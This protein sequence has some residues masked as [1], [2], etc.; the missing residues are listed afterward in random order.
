MFEAAATLSLPTDPAPQF[1]RNPFENTAGRLSQLSTHPSP[2]FDYAHFRN[3]M[4][5]TATRLQPVLSD[6]QNES[7]RLEQFA[8]TVK[9]LSS[10]N[11]VDEIVFL[12]RA[13]AGWGKLL[14]DLDRQKRDGRNLDVVLLD[15]DRN[16]VHQI[17]RTLDRYSDVQSVHIVSHGSDGRV[18]L[19]NTEINGAAWQGYVA[20]LGG[21]RHSLTRSADISFYGCNLAATEEGRQ[22]VRN[23]QL[24]TGAD[25]AASND[26]TGSALAGG[27]WDL[28][29]QLGSVKSSR[30][31][32]ASAQWNWDH[33]LQ[34][35]ID[36]AWLDA[37]GPGP[38]YL[39]QRGETYVLQT[40][41]ATDGSA[42]AII[43]KDIVFDLNGH[44]VTYNNAAP[45]SIVNQSFESGQG[46]SA[47]GWD[48]SAAPTAERYQG[49]WIDN[50]VYDGDYS[51]R[52]GPS[53]LNQTVVSESLVTLEAETTYSLSA[54]FHK[55]DVPD[56]IA[57]V[58]LENMSDGTVYRV[59]YGNN[60]NRGIQFQEEV[61]KTG[62]ADNTYQLRVGVEGAFSENRVIVDDVKVQRT[63]TYGVAVSTFSWAA[64]EYVDFTSY[65]T[66]GNSLIR[67]GDIVQGQ[68]GGTWGHGVLV[69]QAA[70]VTLDNLNVTVAGANAS[71]VYWRSGSDGLIQGSH[72]T[73][74]VK[75]ILSRDNNHGAVIMNFEGTFA[76]NQIHNGP[77]VGLYLSGDA[78]SQVYGNTIRLKSKYTNAFAIFARGVGTDVYDNVIDCG[79]A[80]YSA[81]GIFIRGSEGARRVYD[82]TIR[83]QGMANN[84]EYSGNGGVQLGGAYGI[85]I[86]GDKN[87]EIFRNH[88]YV[89][90]EF[91]M[92]YAFRANGVVDNVNVYE[93]TFT[94][95]NRGSRTAVFKLDGPDSSGLQIYDNTLVT[96]DGIF[97]RTMNT[98]VDLIRS[99]LTIL[100]A[101]D[102]RPFEAGYVSA[103]QTEGH[104]T[105]NLVDTLFADQATRD[106]VAG[107]HFVKYTASAPPESRAEF[108]VR[109]STGFLVKDMMGNLIADAAVRVL[110]AENN[111]V[112]T[113]TTD[114]NGH[115]QI[116]LSE[117]HTTGDVNTIFGEYT[118]TVTGENSEASLSFLADRQQEIDIELGIN[119]PNHGDYSLFYD[120]TTLYVDAT[121]G[122]NQ[123]SWSADD[124]LAFLIDGLHFSVN[125]GTEK[126]HFRG[127]A[128]E[129]TVNLLGS[130]GDDILNLTNGTVVL[131]T[132]VMKM[133]T[134]SIE[135]VNV[136]LG[137][138][139]DHV[140][141]NGTAGDDSLRLSADVANFS[142]SDLTIIANEFERV[143]ARESAG[144]DAVVF[145]D[146]VA[147]DRFYSYASHSLMLSGGLVLRAD[148]FD[149]VSGRSQNGGW[150]TAVLHDSAGNDSLY[151]NDLLGRLTESGGAVREA[152]GFDRTIITS[153]SGQDTASLIGTTE[154]ETVLGSF[155]SLIFMGTGFSHRIN[156]F[157]DVTLLAGMGQD[158]LY[159]NDT[160][161]ND[162][163]Q[164][165]AGN[166]SWSD[167]NRVL[168]ASQ[169]ETQIVRGGSGGQDSIQFMGSQGDEQFYSFPDDEVAF[170]VTAG[171]VLRVTG[172][173]QVEAYSLGGNDKAVMKGMAGFD[174]VRITSGMVELTN[175]A[176]IQAAFGFAETYTYL[177][178]RGDDAATVS[179]TTGND[180]LV[181]SQD[182]VRFYG[183]GYSNFF[184]GFKSAAINAGDGHDAFYLKDSAHDDQVV[185]RSG[186][187]TVANPSFSILLNHFETQVVSS[188]NGGF[189]SVQMFDSEWDDYLYS[190]AGFTLMQNSRSFHR[191]NGFA[192]VSAHASQGGADTV[193]IH[194]TESQDQID[195]ED[196]HGTYRGGG[197]DRYFEGFDHADIY[198]NLAVDRTS[199]N[200]VGFDFHWIDE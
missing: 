53:G 96:N 159:L 38:Y 183:D 173:D 169:F 100:P 134:S 200:N 178:N 137:T 160:E 39:D 84:Q 92:G 167:S 115:A 138:G 172:F 51:L 199:E 10:R 76:N 22:L 45:I 139:N 17:S 79:H 155:D 63:R 120:G 185:M 135:N 59:D 117:L 5:A 143:V 40:D 109:W 6:I 152:Q 4:A 97:G 66:A 75:T 34:I 195:L 128:G 89:N 146:T 150:D 188:V 180:T 156:G 8:N 7:P 99:N 71:A 1:G 94:V 42:F 106:A 175:S 102:R 149:S 68:D 56:V 168:V 132:P 28:E 122:Q 174:D 26:L 141:L 50:E 47:D 197:L 176:G 171:G 131:T 23:V 54:M 184:S 140:Y 48:F 52:F 142:T 193:E 69:R 154:K 36:Q 81:R 35:D 25:V 125:Q 148:G 116:V 124:P 164:M 85:Q 70:D 189:D 101:E 65:G 72:F 144:H 14:I 107:S 151:A 11:R 46:T 198:L 163:I 192:V 118:V 20:E 113:G 61:F 165:R 32:S 105:V 58:E 21:W 82:N 123:F 90:A 78:S 30:L 129:D 43:A 60:N 67:N 121:D 37:Q 9:D 104:T 126:I 19:G 181:G 186:S 130:T 18:Q 114:A 170:M 119:P 110:D 166:L 15:T 2:G 3:L 31:F 147:N 194:G 196:D 158:E 87:A 95:D 179:A 29:F 74:N 153:S 162:A 91:T 177:A 111:E 127:D 24:I 98:H 93:N 191:A 182:W 62:A 112:F 187:T 27:D 41:V 57:F 77:H 161:D 44:T 190:V 49:I 12:D 64:E 83:V 73:S 88:V 16:G 55:K 86:E 136:Q 108:N 13:V 145:V 80:D 133:V 157:A 33:T 103:S